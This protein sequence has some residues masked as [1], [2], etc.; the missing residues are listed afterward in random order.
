MRRSGKRDSATSAI[1][2]GNLA[3]EG[4]VAK[5]TGKEGDSFSGP[6]RVF[7]SEE[8]M[9]AALEQ[10]RI[11][12]GDV[13]VIRYEGP[14]GGPGMPE[15]LTPTSALA[16][17]GLEKHVALI[18]DGRFSGG[19]H[20][21]LIGHVTPEAQDGGP[22]ALVRDGD[23]ITIDARRHTLDVE[24]AAAELERRRAR[25]ARA[26]RSRRR[27]ARCSSTSRTC[28]RPPRA[29]SP[30]NDVTTTRG[31]RMSWL[32]LLLSLWGA[33]FTWNALRPSWDSPRFAVV[34]FAAGWLTSELALHHLVWQV[35]GD[36]GLRHLRRVRR[37]GPGRLGL[38]IT[39]ASWAGL[40]VVQRQA[41]D[42][43]PVLERALVSA[44]G[45]GYRQQIAPSLRDEAHGTASSG[46]ASGGPF[47]IKRPDVEIVKNI[48]FDRAQGD[49]S[50]SSTSIAAA[51]GRRAA[52][53]SSRST[54]AAG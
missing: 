35:V 49:G 17:T 48:R 32:F 31:P 40:L 1:L 22:I 11:A 8:D 38:L 18:T 26:A 52:P 7:D 29:A 5:I 16:G 3:P 10:S 50:R 27:A 54:A 34:S 15:M 20:G 13:I 45:T 2:R 30:T 24:L 6:A 41:H 37:S 43:E 9:L 33:W 46:C 23:R 14:R 28:A 19:S 39:C 47:P 4:A 12:T 21:F 44:L 53:C 25:V 36:A 51:R 42:A